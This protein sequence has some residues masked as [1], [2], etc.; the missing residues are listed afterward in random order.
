MVRQNHRRQL[1]VLLAWHLLDASL[2]VGRPRLYA[3]LVHGCE[4]RRCGEEPGPGRG[5]AGRRWHVRSGR[6]A[7]R[8]GHRWNGPPCSSD[9]A[10]SASGCVP[11]GTATTASRIACF[12]SATPPATGC[13]S[14]SPPAACCV[15]RWPAR[16]RSRSREATSPPGGPGSGITSSW[17]GSPTEISRSDCRS[18]S[19]AW[20]WM[21]PW[22]AGADSSIRRRLTD[23]RLW[24]GD[25][26]SQADIDELICR[27]RLDAEGSWG[28]V[29]TVYRDYFRTAPY[30][31]IRMDRQAA[32]GSGGPSRRRGLREAARH[33]GPPGGPVG[34][35]HGFRRT[36][37]PVGILRRQAVHRLG[38]HRCLHCDRRC[39]WSRQRR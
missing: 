3:G 8:C 30:D 32:A 37:L 14:R 20:P 10:T 26:S 36:L 35:D 19:T 28:L 9:R 15:S 18:G 29:A 25:A 21:A 7:G 17:P 23:K 22:P 16:R 24:I 27:D 39:E 34:A 12:G 1:G 38:Q 13:S 11:S 4:C 31:A 5:V 33:S 6:C 2:A